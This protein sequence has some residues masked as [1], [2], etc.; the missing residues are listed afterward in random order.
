MKFKLL[1]ISFL[2]IFKGISQEKWT[3]KRCI[4]YAIENN[5]SIKQ[6]KLNLKNNQ[7]NIKEAKGNFL[8]GVS[9]S[10]G[11][12]LNF[13]SSINPITNSRVGT[14]SIFSGNLGVGANV[15]V[16]NGF[17]NINALKRAGLDTETANLELE[18][19]KNDVTLNV[20]NAYLNVLFAKENLQVAKTQIEIS[21]KQVTRVQAQYDEGTTAKT[22]LLNIKATVA[23][24]LQNVVTQENNLNLALLN[25][26]QLLQIPNDNFDVA[27]IKTLQLPS[28]FPY[29][30]SN[31]VLEKALVNQPQILKGELDIKKASLGI[32]IAKG[33]YFPSVSASANIG[34]RFGYN[35]KTDNIELSKQLENNFGYGGSL[36][37]N[38]PIFSGFKTNIA[39]ERAKINKD[40]IKENLEQQ[41]LQLHQTIEK[42]YLD[43]K[44]AQKTYQSAEASLMAQKEAFKNAQE[45]YNSGTSSIFDFEQVRNRLVNAEATLIRAKY[46]Y[47]FKT[48]VLHFYY[49]ENITE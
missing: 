13:G 46:D 32:N 11:N 6:S 36:N 2:F 44:S 8:P 47:V 3:L 5:I 7:A 26:S 37:I 9:G 14:S 28:L 48:K 30:S 21:K 10:L 4:L 25:L 49:G 19:I 35:L 24:D 42:A 38:I 16:F 31:I 27:P 41:K 33:A 20:V 22:N 23:N 45:S 29:T 1:L 40:I 43:A 18:K 17:R 34:T 39:V 15:Q 12:S